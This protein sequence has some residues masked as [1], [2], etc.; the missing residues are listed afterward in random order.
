MRMQLNGKVVDL[1]NDIQ[2]VK[3]LLHYLELANRTVVVE[4]NRE[5]LDLD[6][7]GDVLLKDGDCLEIVQFV[8]GG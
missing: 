5:I 1:P 7:H 2:S 6:K 4:K 8:G 3:E